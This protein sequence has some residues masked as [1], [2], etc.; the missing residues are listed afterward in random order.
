MA[1]KY[2][3]LD[4]SQRYLIGIVGIPG[5]GKTTFA[6]SLG[7]SLNKVYHDDR[8]KKFPNAADYD[9]SKAKSHSGSQH[10][11]HWS[12][13]TTPEI[14]FVLP[15]DGFH[16]SRAQ[17][18]AMSNPEEAR[19]RRGAAFTFDAD[20][21]LALIQKLR[22]PIEPTTRTVFA[23]SFDHAIKDPIADDIAIPR[24][25]R[26]VIVEGLYVALK[27]DGT[28]LSPAWSEAC[29]LMDEVWHISVPIPVAT[30]RVAKRNFQAG[31]S[32]TLE[33]ALD[34]TEKNDM[35]NARE[36]LDNLNRQKVTETIES[37]DDEG[38]KS[39]EQHM[40]VGDDDEDM[41]R[42]KLDRM[43]SI[44]ELVDAGAGM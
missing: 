28:Q 33:A 1:E 21:Y 31:L 29:E 5:S 11:R 17:L 43:G 12:G 10:A 7:Y 18:S 30:E 36:I 19:Y 22:R 39:Q 42:L 3:G 23:P 20:A 13:P 27:S 41:K 35:R 24:T 32:P 44:A 34:R 15:M 40:K 2:Q 25:A 16:L 6:T 26:V 14:A 38:W 8:K 4:D 9:F 37:I